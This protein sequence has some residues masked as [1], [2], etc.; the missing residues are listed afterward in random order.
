MR[1]KRPKA[2]LTPLLTLPAAQVRRLIYT[3]RRESRLDSEIAF[4]ARRIVSLFVYSCSPLCKDWRRLARSGSIAEVNRHLRVLSAYTANSTAK[5][6]LIVAIAGFILAFV[7]ALSKP[8][9]RFAAY[10]LDVID[11]GT[12]RSLRKYRRN[13]LRSHGTSYNLF[14]HSPEDLDIFLRRMYLW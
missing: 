7:I 1:Q 2:S 14:Q 9:R 8:V 13:Y 11:A 4:C 5:W 12:G 3:R 6:T 10:L